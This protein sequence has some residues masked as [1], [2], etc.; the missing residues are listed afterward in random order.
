MSPT[1]VLFHFPPSDTPERTA[2]DGEKH[3][4]DVKTVHGSVIEF[5]HSFITSEERLSRDNFYPKLVWVVDGLRRKR[6]KE[7]FFN[8]L[9]DGVQIT[10]NPMLMKI[11]TEESRILNEWSSSKVPVFFDCKV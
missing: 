5:Q 10:P 3:I 11:Y 6:D 2:D 7:Q 8:A 9:K 1:V 4:A